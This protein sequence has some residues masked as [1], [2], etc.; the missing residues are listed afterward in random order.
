MDGCPL[1]TEYFKDGDEV[2][3]G[4]CPLHRGTIRQRLVRAVQGWADELGRRLRDVFR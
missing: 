3:E 2:P 1:Y 4:L